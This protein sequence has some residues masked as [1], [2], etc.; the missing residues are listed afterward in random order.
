M[1]VRDSQG[2][3]VQINNHY[4]QAHRLIIT[5]QWDG[6][7][8]QKTHYQYD[9]KGNKTAIIDENG[10]QIIFEYDFLGRQI[11]VISDQGTIEKQ[12]DVLGR[13]VAE[14][15]PHGK[16]TYEYNGYGNPAIIH[17]ADQRTEQFIYNMD[18][19][20]NLSIN[21]KGQQTLYYR[22]ASGKIR[23]VEN[24]VPSNVNSGQKIFSIFDSISSF[25]HDH[26][27]LEHNFKSKIESALQLFLVRIV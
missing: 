21:S 14:I 20:L 15:T 11:K 13:Q 12:Y 23:K 4:D 3:H 1:I 25:I 26:L 16:T 9:K 22:E 7:V 17:Y 8:L 2:S 10:H 18:G 27:S 5:E 24:V 6:K 19:S